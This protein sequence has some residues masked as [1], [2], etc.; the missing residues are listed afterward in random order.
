MANRQNN[1][2]IQTN[3]V[4]RVYLSDGELNKGGKEH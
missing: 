3:Y 4:C 2:E 1:G